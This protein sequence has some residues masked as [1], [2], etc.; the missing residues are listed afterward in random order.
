MENPTLFQ[1]ADFEV[2]TNS[3][4]KIPAKKKANPPREHI[5]LDE[6]KL[7]EYATEFLHGKK[8]NPLYD[9]R[10]F[11]APG[12]KTKPTVIWQM[13]GNLGGWVENSDI[14]I[15][16]DF[17]I[18][19]DTMV[20]ALK[21]GQQDPLLLEVEKKMNGKGRGYDGLRIVSEGTFLAFVRRR[22]EETGDAVMQN[23]LNQAI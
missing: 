15:S 22:S 12:I 17:V 10:V 20:E 6:N 5:H 21:N 14:G 18:I 13:V 7:G 16:T 2:Q 9:R 23:L 1:P 4:E 11:F 19:P 3:E 8:F